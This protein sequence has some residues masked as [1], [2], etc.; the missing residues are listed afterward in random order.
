MTV[1]SRKYYGCSPL[2]LGESYGGAGARITT[3]ELSSVNTT[4]PA[5]QV[6]KVLS[7]SCLV[8][9]SELPLTPPQACCKLCYFVTDCRKYT[10]VKKIDGIDPGQVWSANCTLFKK[11]AKKRPNPGPSK[12][13]IAGGVLNLEPPPAG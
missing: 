11:T 9:A 3:V 12:F 5:L 10:F 7:V 8:L 2:G 6:S 1:T 4:D 13:I